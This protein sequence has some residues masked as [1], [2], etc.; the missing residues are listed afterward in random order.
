[1][2]IFILLRLEGSGSDRSWSGR[3][4]IDDG[5]E[6]SFGRLGGILGR[7]AVERV[8]FD[9]GVSEWQVVTDET[10]KNGDQ[11]PGGLG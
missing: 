4:K 6:G 9:Q 10:R 8:E 3:W 11:L 1:L 5:G 7:R 2:G